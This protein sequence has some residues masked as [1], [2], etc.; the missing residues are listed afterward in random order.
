MIRSSLWRPVPKYIYVCP[1]CKRPTSKMRL[2]DYAHIP[3]AEQMRRRPELVHI[4]SE[5]LGCPCGEI[6]TWYDVE[7]QLHSLEF[8]NVVLVTNKEIRDET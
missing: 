7:Y 1:H 3:S 5:R 2:I 8:K 6:I 4:G